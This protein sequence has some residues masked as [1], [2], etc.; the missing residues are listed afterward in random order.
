MWPTL[1]AIVVCLYCDIYIRTLILHTWRYQILFSF[2]VS[3]MLW[4]PNVIIQYRIPQTLLL[5]IRYSQSYTT[6]TCI[7]NILHNT[8]YW[9]VAESWN[10]VFIIFLET[11]GYWH[12]DSG[13]S[14]IWLLKY[15]RPSLLCWG[16][17]F[18]IGT[19]KTVTAILVLNCERIPKFCRYS[20]QCCLHFSACNNYFW[21][22]IC[23]YQSAADHRTTKSTLQIREFC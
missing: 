13:R 2:V 6:Y 5:D 3:P 17:C 4:A 10:I 11:S 22:D 7:S 8:F 1:L 18:H 20:K 21:C 15:I 23:T 9:G 12:K 14:K 19:S 16:I